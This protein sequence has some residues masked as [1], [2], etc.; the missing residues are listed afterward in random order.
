MAFHNLAKELSTTLGTAD[1]V[2]SG[3]IAGFNT[4]EDAGVTD[5]ETINYGIVTFDITTHRPTFS[6]V[7]IGVY[8]VATKTVTRAS[9]VDS[10]NGGAKIVLTG[11]SWVFIPALSQNLLVAP[12]WEQSFEE[13]G[14]SFANWTSGGGTWS[15]D[16][17]VIKQTDTGA[18]WRTAFFNA[19]QQLAPSFVL[20]AEIKAV[21]AG[22]GALHVVGLVVGYSGTNSSPGMEAELRLDGGTRKFNFMRAFTSDNLTISPYVW[23]D[24]T[25]YTL[26]IATNGAFISA[27]ING[28]LVASAGSAGDIAG[29]ARYLG[30]VSYGCEAHFKNISGW[31]M[32]LPPNA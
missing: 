2:V 22:A 21:A 19:V 23:S 32:P 15:S 9:V 11:L 5:G 17:T 27:F 25:F 8:D 10:T 6:E 29:D 31:A 26:K 7:G 14:A 20:Q 28:T 4:L 18:T 30:L 3:A 16:G 13:T 12:V 1:A 24:D